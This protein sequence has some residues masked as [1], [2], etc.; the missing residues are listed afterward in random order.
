[1]QQFLALAKDSLR[2]SM[3]RK[4]FWVMTAL[5]VL[6]AAGMF[7]FAFEPG[8][9]VVLFG[10]WE[11]ETAEFTSAGSV[12]S[13]RIAGLAVHIIW[14]LMLGFVG[15]TLAL[16]AT[17]GFLP[18]FMERGAIEVVLSKPMA[19]W[20][21]FLAK[22]LG[23]MVFI[24]AQATLFVVLTYMVIGFRWGVWLPGYLLTIP[25]SVILF[26]YLY[27]VS[28]LVAVWSRSTVAAAL[29]SFGAWVGF[30]GV[31]TTADL[32]DLY[33]SWQEQTVACKAIRAA[34][35]IVPKTQDI[36]YLAA[37][38]V[39]A[40]A[41]SE[42]VP[43]GEGEDAELVRR[44]GA[45]EEERME[46]NPVHTLGSSLLFEAVIVLLAIWKFSRTDY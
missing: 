23:S 24:L 43:D 36:T 2:E 10:A 12:Q 42:V 35:W 4:I 5:S 25:L 40:G 11:F 38:W 30:F 27:C 20:K 6:V 3:D 22:Y 17:A 41:S 39:G 32:F 9:V 15:V 18:A 19:R 13:S 26:S 1:M 28:A 33:P 46:I 45:L 14:D 44:A 29:M 8:R 21:V 31:Q 7:C 37:R 16:V 34:R